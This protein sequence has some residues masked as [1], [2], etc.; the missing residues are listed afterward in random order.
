M[1]R[2]LL[3]AQ[4]LAPGALLYGM[5]FGVLASERGF[6]LMQALLMSLFVYSGTAQLAVIQGWSQTQA[7]LPVVVTV[8]VINARYV[9]YGAAIQPWLAGASRPQAFVSLFT[10]GDSNWALAMREYHAGYR[11]SGFVLGSGIAM[12]LPWLAGTV[13]GQLLGRS[14]PNPVSFGLDFMLPAFAAAIGISVW[15]GQRGVAPAIAAALAALALMHL[16][17]GAWYI[18]GAGLAAGMAGAWR[19]GR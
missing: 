10:L 2:G 6:S 19:H 8:L 16:V 9:L 11:D 12:A 17:P 4:P 7:L 3:L 15:P 13:A 5:V 18:V 14:V 1:R